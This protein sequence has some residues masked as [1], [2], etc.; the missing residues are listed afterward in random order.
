MSGLTNRMDGCSLTEHWNNTG[1]IHTTA[2]SVF[3]WKQKYSTWHILALTYPPLQIMPP[4]H[5]LDFIFASS[6]QFRHITGKRPALLMFMLGCKRVE[7][8]GKDT[9]HASSVLK[10]INSPLD[11]S[12]TTLT[13]SSSAHTENLLMCPHAHDQYSGCRSSLEVEQEKDVPQ[14][15]LSSYSM[16][17]SL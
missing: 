1:S 12:S 17:W 8:V 5:H 4:D 6:R 10:R 14:A 9:P 15:W 2:A 7:N 3:D 11:S 13:H 16:W